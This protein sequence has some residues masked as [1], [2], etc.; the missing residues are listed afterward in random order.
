M[1][2]RELLEAAAK[3][4]G[5]RGWRSKHGYWNIDGPDGK[6]HTCCANWASYSASTGEKFPEPTFAD[7]LA[8]VGWNPLDDDGDALRLAVRRRFTVAVRDHECEVFSDEG[9][10]LASEPIFT[11]SAF[12][13]P[14]Q[15]TDP[16]EATR[17]AIVRAAAAPA[18]AQAA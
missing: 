13:K 15:A 5:W 14:E 3:A 10:C 17:R 2:D 11:A 16:A 8:E 18:T 7:A 9:E 1:E 12:V 4:A 6:A